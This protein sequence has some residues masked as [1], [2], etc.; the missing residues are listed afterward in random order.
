MSTGDHPLASGIPGE[1]L[2][3]VPKAEC[4][5]ILADPRVV[6]LLSQK[7]TI[8]ATYDNPYIAGY[9]KNGKIVYIDRDFPYR[10]F[11]VGTKTINALPFLLLHETVEKAILMVFK[12]TYQYAHAIATYAEEKAA[13]AAGI[14]IVAYEKAYAKFDKSDYNKR[15]LRVAPDLDLKPYVDSKDTKLLAKLRAAMARTS[16]SSTNK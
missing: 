9:S 2:Q 15:L 3:D 14:D 8:D 4:E 16:Y 5:R 13:K 1:K 6:K 10:T 7:P 12:S 11:K